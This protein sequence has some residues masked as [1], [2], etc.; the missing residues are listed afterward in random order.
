MPSISK[1]QQ[2]VALLK[3]QEQMLATA[4]SCTG[5]LIAHLITQ[6]AGASS[7][8]DRGYVT[9]SNAAKQEELNVP[10]ETL[11]RYGAV[12]AQTAQAMALGAIANSRASVAL[13]VT[14]IAGPDGGTKDK[15]VGLVY[16]GLA[17]NDTETKSFEY[18]FS[19]TRNEIQQ[20]TAQRALQI[21]IEALTNH[22]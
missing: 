12:S 2:A 6:I 21:L 18:H 16:I 19:G 22:D 8:F 17:Q 14:G 13:S 5:G 9:Y 11:S 10:Q 15:P 4:E 7:V 20:E 3:E 1:A